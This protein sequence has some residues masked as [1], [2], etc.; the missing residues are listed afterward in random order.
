MSI[1]LLLIL[2]IDSS[3]TYQTVPEIT[4]IANNNFD[5]IRRFESLCLDIFC[6]LSSR[7]PPD[8]LLHILDR[9]SVS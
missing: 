3:M 8:A 5:A 1:F 6:R 2:L 7:Q 9:S 4:K